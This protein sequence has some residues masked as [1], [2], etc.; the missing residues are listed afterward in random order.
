MAYPPPGPGYG[1]YPPAPGY[2]PTNAPGYPPSGMGYPPANTQVRVVLL[3]FN[4]YVMKMCACYDKAVYI[5][6][7]L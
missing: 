6:Y 2:P 1:G 3:L 4:T 5:T 7:L